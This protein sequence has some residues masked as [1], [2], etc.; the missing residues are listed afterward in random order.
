MPKV[1]V[2][3]PSRNEVFLTPT[4]KD[5]LAKA[6]GDIE[7][8]INIDEK[9]PDEIVEDPRV[10]YFYPG[11]PIGMRAGV[12]FLASKAKGEF[13]MKIDAHCIVDQGFDT[14]LTNDCDD[15]WVVIPRRYRLDPK[16]WTVKQTTETEPQ[17]D[18]E[19]LIYP[20]MYNP[21]SLHGF[22]WDE[23]T[24]TRK[25]ILIDDN[26]TFQGSLWFMKK[27]WFEKNGF[28]QVDGYQGLPQQ[29]AEEIGIT[30]WTRG[31]RVV[32]NK[33]TWYAH[34]HKGGEFGRGYPLSQRQFRDCYAYSYNHWVIENKE[35][36]IKLI[37]KFWPIPGWN[38]DWKEK[39]YK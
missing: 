34:L 15:N 37:E 3:I 13:L 9:R 6:E 23:R 18:Y 22:R 25:D 17:I 1:S 30:T 4:V 33:K 20:R 32:V 16:T 12:N 29:E 7:I 39:L 35:G 27:T 10:T 19:H 26:M 31:G 21:V 24:K 38:P 2:I 14:K 36:F 8:L 5:L 11:T 28:E